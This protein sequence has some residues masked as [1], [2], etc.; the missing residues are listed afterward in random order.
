MSDIFV[1]YK[2]DDRDRVR[3]IIDALEAAGW[4]VWWDTHIEAGRAFGL[5]KLGPEPVVNR[6]VRQESS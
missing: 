2:S 1:S 5:E 4:E 6:P 3:P